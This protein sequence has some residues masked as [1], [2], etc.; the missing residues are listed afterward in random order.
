MKIV[1]ACTLALALAGCKKHAQ[2]TLPPIASSS[3]MGGGKTE[4]PE[5]TLIDVW[6]SVPKAQ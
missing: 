5:E 4:L 1:L 6:E 3:P 2:P